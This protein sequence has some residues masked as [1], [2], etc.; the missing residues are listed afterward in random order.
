MEILI[1]DSKVTLSKLEDSEIHT[2][3]SDSSMLTK[4]IVLDSEVT[5]IKSDDSIIERRS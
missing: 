2:V 1:Q 5:V 3:L 4:M